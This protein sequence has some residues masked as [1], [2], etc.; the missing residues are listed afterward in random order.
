MAGTTPTFRR[1]RAGL[2]LRLGFKAPVLLYHGPLAE[3]LRSRCVMLLTT[4]GRK[5]G[6]PRTNGVSF[7][8][9]DDRY[10]IFSGWGTTSNWYRNLRANPEVVAQ[11]GRRRVRATARLV[12]DPER[13]LELM[14]RMRDRSANCGPPQFI[15]PLL[16][17]TRAFDYDAEIAMAVEHARELPVVELIPHGEHG[18]T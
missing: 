18:D 13:R 11:V 17:L 10:V 16:A 1:Q 12:E 14:L 15:R 7:M 6:L 2:A 4:T 5:S 9:L 8:P 3:L